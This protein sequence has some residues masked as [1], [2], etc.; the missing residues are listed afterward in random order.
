MRYGFPLATGL[1]LW[2]A[3]IQLTGWFAYLLCGWGIV[4]LVAVIALAIHDTKK[5]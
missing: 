2:F 4:H 3:G 5:V 1:L